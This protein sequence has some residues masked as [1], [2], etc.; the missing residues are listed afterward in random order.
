MNNTCPCQSHY[1]DNG[2]NKKCTECHPSCVG[3][4][5]PDPT[6]CLSCDGEL[7]R[8]LSVNENEKICVCKD[9]YYEEEKNNVCVKC[10]YSCKTCDGPGPYECSSCPNF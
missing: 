4:E 3:C 5:G 9:G 1:H 6:N 7:N 10:H 2:K 8:I